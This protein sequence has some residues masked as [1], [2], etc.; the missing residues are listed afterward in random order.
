MTLCVTRI[1]RPNKSRSYTRCYRRYCGV[2]ALTELTEPTMTV[3]V[4]EVCGDIGADEAAGQR[5]RRR[6]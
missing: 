3:H 5:A 6:R 4:K 1:L 2:T